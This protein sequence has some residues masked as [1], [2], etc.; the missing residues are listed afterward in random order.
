M[1]D[2]IFGDLTARVLLDS[3][4]CSVSFLQLLEPRVSSWFVFRLA[5][6]VCQVTTLRVTFHFEIDRMT[7]IGQDFTKGQLCVL[8]DQ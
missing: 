4:F 6:L 8:G 5:T 3:A 1:G 7:Y 2:V